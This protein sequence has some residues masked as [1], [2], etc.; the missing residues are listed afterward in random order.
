MSGIDPRLLSDL[1]R[2]YDGDV[3]RRNEAELDF[4]K[5]II[6]KWADQL[7]PGA[8]IIELGAGTGQAAAHLTDR[9]F[10]VLATDLSPQNVAM[11]R[12]R[13]LPAVVADMARI[14]EL[15][16]PE[17]APPYEAAFAINSLIHIPK[18]LLTEALRSI[19]TTL[20]P[21]AE[22]LG[23][24]WGGEAGEGVWDEDWT[25]PPRFFSVY[26]DEEL[27]SWAFPAFERIGFEALE[28]DPEVGM[29]S[30]VVRLRA[31]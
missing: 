4:R 13:G 8:R 18:H 12:E 30:L 10:D 3:V 1:A 21:G 14:G 6:D 31:V 22:L 11:C 15:T 19:R 26:A 29:H 23:V 9:G 25:D 16:A 28:E 7:T 27:R 24:F 17:F 2:A 5:P 20:K